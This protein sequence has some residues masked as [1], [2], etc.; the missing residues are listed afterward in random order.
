M[1]RAISAHPRLSLVAE[2]GNGID[3]LK[4]IEELTPDVALLDARMPGLN[5]L[6]VCD[7]VAAHVPPLRTRVLLV[8]ADPD[9]FSIVE[10]TAI[11]AQG[12]LSKG[13]SRDELCAALVR[14]SPSELQLG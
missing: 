4:A 1:A 11:G 6:T 9:E 13:S 12:L 7:R 8:T 14:V 3:A 5:G 10:A 2:V